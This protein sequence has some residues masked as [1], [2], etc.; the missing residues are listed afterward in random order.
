MGGTVLPSIGSLSLNFSQGNSEVLSDEKF[1]LT[2]TCL[3][4]SHCSFLCGTRLPAE[5]CIHSRVDL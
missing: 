4:Q 5:G 1:G 3:V 2:E